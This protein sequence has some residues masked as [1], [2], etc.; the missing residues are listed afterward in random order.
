MRGATRIVSRPSAWTSRPLGAFSM[1][2]S[3]GQTRSDSERAL[4]TPSAVRGALAGSRSRGHARHLAGWCGTMA[5]TSACAASRGQCARRVDCN[6]RIT[7]YAVPA[8]CRVTRRT[9]RQPKRRVRQEGCDAVQR[10]RLRSPASPSTICSPRSPDH[11]ADDPGVRHSTCRSTRTRRP[12]LS[13][14]MKQRR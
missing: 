6:G 14:A 2:L 5:M 12:S 10:W 1:G 3:G 7:R 11:H 4:C 9:R 8:S 13:L